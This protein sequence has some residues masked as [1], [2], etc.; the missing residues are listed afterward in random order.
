MSSDFDALE[1]RLDASEIQGNILGGFNKDHQAVL[2]LKFG[3]DVATVAAVRA[4]VGSILS[5]I[6]WLSEVV[7]FKR[8]RKLR[9]AAEGLEPTDMTALWRNIAF[10]YPGLR[11]LTEQADGFEPI[12]RDGLPAA[13]FRIGDPGQEGVEGNVS[14]WV[15][16]MPGEI[17]DILFIIAGDDAEEVG[18]EVVVFLQRAKEAGIECLF[19]DIGH[20]LSFYSTEQIQFQKGREHFGFKDGISQPGVRGRMSATPGDFLTPRTI[21][22]TGDPNS[23]A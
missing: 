20:D 11:K 5:S 3:D 14:T 4:W 1:P 19:Q 17:P 21:L 9:I 7:N 6:T 13:S 18:K 12:F 22:D 2:L 15:V 8:D 10:S 16:G 23:P